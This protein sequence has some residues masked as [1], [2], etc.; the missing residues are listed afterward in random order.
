MCANKANNLQHKHQEMFRQN[1]FPKTFFYDS[2]GF[3]KDSGNIALSVYKTL[4]NVKPHP[5]MCF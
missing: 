2:L 1:I 5:K 4:I 3:R